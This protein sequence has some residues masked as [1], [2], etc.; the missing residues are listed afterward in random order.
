MGALSAR[1]PKWLTWRVKW[2]SSS[3]SLTGTAASGGA[4][5]S[6]AGG[7]SSGATTGS[8]LPTTV[9][10]ARTADTSAAYMN[11]SEGRF[12]KS[13]S[14]VTLSGPATARPGRM[15]SAGGCA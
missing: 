9:H 15:T 13:R 12:C 8:A 5:G 3:S 4:G 2:I 6:G 14:M 7:G 10:C 11:R 1:V